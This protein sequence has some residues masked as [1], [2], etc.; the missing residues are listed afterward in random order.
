[1]RKAKSAGAPA[2]F[3]PLFRRAWNWYGKL[4][5]VPDRKLVSGD[6]QAEICI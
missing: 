4:V 5:T 3:E 2:D 6:R 1:V